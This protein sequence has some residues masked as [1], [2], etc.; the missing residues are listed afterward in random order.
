[1]RSRNH[2]PFRMKK[3][4]P[5]RTVVLSSDQSQSAR[6]CSACG[7]LRTKLTCGNPRLR[8]CT[9]DA[10]VSGRAK[11]CENGGED[12]EVQVVTAAG[13][14]AGTL[15]SV[16]WFIRM[17]RRCGLRVRFGQARHRRPSAGHRLRRS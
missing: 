15:L 10:R 9:A 4:F 16:L 1:M 13:V 5:E 12:L 8:A 2:R 7:P 6:T 17:L 3:D 14:A 11:G